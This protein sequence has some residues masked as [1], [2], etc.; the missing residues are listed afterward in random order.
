MLALHL[1]ISWLPAPCRQY[2]RPRPRPAHLL[3]E[4]SR[5]ML[6]VVSLMCSFKNAV[7]FVVR[8]Q[9]LYAKS[10]ATWMGALKTIPNVSYRLA[11]WEIFEHQHLKHRNQ[12]MCIS[13]IQFMVSGHL[14][15]PHMPELRHPSLDIRRLPLEREPVGPGAQ[16]TDFCGWSITS[17]TQFGMSLDRLGSRR[18]NLFASK[19]SLNWPPAP[20][21]GL[22]ALTLAHP[23][24]WQ[25]SLMHLASLPP[26]SSMKTYVANALH[27]ETLEA[28]RHKA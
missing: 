12:R 4:R 2:A 18:F 5:E 25:R 19:T 1:P 23:S 26:N 14:A 21:C 27:A 10:A 15:V 8:C 11:V 17:K 7:S 22:T 24:H 28:V 20:P 3:G 6:G 13:R 16:N 9:T